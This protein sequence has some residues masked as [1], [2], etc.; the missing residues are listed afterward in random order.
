MHEF[1]D[2]TPFEDVSVETMEEV[3]KVVCGYMP[4]QG[5][6]EKTILVRVNGHVFYFTGAQL[7]DSARKLAD[8]IY[9]AVM[10]LASG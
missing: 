9:N 5:E 1:Q 7:I 4:A 2:L 10:A 6:V 8:A 3:K